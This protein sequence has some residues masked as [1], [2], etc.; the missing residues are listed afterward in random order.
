MSIV[1]VQHVRRLR[2]GAQSHL[3]RCNDGELYVV[4]FQNNPQHVRVLAN[5]M[6]ATRLAEHA[7]L[8]VAAVQVVEVEPWLVEHSPELNIQLAGRTLA[9][10]PGLQFGSRY[11]LPPQDGQVLDWL[12]Q[13]MIEDVRNLR[14]F[15]GALALD[16]WTCNADGRQAIFWRKARERKYSAAFVDHGYCFNAGEWSF[17][18]SPLR[19]AY[20]WNEV[21]AG[22]TGWESFEPWLSRLEQTPPEVIAAAAEEIAPEWYGKDWDALEKLVDALVRRRTRIRDLILEF[23]GSSR[24]PFP[25]WSSSQNGK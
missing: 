13:T 3:M 23:R 4:K 25:N 19:G 7:G 24:H 15:A 6:L 9:C 14:A 8:P 16:K 17:P 5:E 2:G 10:A 18:D 11:V 12:P 20:P 1:A 21:Y 22:V